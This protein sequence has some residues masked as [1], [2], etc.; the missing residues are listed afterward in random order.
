M[1]G[2]FDIIC[3][4]ATVRRKIFPWTEYKKCRRWF[5]IDIYVYKLHK[6]EALYVFNPTS[7][8]FG[9][10]IDIKKSTQEKS[11]LSGSRSSKRSRT[12]TRVT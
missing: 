9:P 12:R 1:N 5:L 3:Y 4:V 8:A 11:V 7:R 6:E 2:K 10:A